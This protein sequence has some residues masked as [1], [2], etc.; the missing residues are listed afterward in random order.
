LVSSLPV[1]ENSEAAIDLADELLRSG[2]VPEEATFDAVHIAV[3]AVHA[4][5][6]LVTWDFKRIA[7]PF[8]RERIRSRVVAHGFPMPTMR[9]PEELLTENEGD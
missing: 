6:F 3:T 7:N 2:I 4:V 1:L 9:G 8:L 5:E